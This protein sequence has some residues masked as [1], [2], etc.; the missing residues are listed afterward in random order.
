MLQQ[1][2]VKTVIPYYQRWLERF[3][4]LEAVAQADLQTV[5]KYW[6]GLG[7]YARCRNFKRA[8][9]IVVARYGGRVPADWDTLRA[10]PGVGD[11]TAAA[12]LSTAS[13]LPLPAVDGNVRRVTARLLARRTL[14]PHNLRLMR[15]HL[16]RWISPSR[17]GAFNQALMDLGSTICRPNQPHCDVCPIQSHCLGW[18]RGRPAAYPAPPPR[19]S[20]PR[21]EVVVG[22]IWRDDRFLIRR[23]PETGL[24]GGLWEFPGGKVRA[25]EPPQAALAREIAEECDLSVRIGKK[26]GTVRHAY[27]HFAIRM[28]LYHCR[29]NGHRPRSPRDNERWI[30]PSDIDHYPFPAANH[31]LFRLL[32]DQEWG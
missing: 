6:E 26:V 15:S 7:Y 14:S 16:G 9:E 23:R 24:L 20:I 29:L 13:H 10:L 19:R 3:P 5:L 30:R 12:V 4:D 27:S 11:Y 18:W 1:T 17:P 2:Q 8:V 22:I 28:T 32:A 21:Y 31:K 25:E